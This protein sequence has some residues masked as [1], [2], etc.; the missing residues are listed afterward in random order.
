MPAI[1]PPERPSSSELPVEVT[2]GAAEVDEAIDE[3]AEL[4]DPA[5]AEVAAPARLEVIAAAMVFYGYGLLCAL[6]ANNDTAAGKPVE[7]TAGGAI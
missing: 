6:T 4:L 5:S 7:V 2:D 3:E 1:W